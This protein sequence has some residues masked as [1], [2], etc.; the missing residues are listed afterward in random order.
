[1]PLV[2]RVDNDITSQLL[3]HMKMKIVLGS[4]HEN[5]ILNHMKMK[6]VLG[7]RQVIT[8]NMM[9]TEDLYNH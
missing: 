1:M 4:R 3:N 5:S 6:I 9:V 7:S 2:L 8:N